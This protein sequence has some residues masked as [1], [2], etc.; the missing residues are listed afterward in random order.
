[1][2]NRNSTG[3]FIK[4]FA[5]WNKGMPMSLEQRA[6]LVTNHRGMT[7]RHFS[8]ESKKK[9]SLAHTGKVVSQTTKVNM[10]MAR[11]RWMAGRNHNGNWGVSGKRIINGREQFFR[12][13]WEANAARLLDYLKIKWEYEVKTFWFDGIKRGTR[14]Y[15]PDFYLPDENKYIEV[16]GWMDKK[17]LTRMKRMAKYYPEIK[18]ELWDKD[19]FTALRQ[20]GIPKLI[21]EWE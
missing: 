14:S 4:G 8:D 13:R 20:Q 10:S 2:V 1:M 5:P 11:V 21:P 7:G 9:I 15:T 19:Y 18:I 16:K 17:S 12:S 3:Q 6:K